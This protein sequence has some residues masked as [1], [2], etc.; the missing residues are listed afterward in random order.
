[1]DKNGK[2]WGYME[3]NEA[4]KDTI[5]P[6]IG[7]GKEIISLI[8]EHNVSESSWL[9]ILSIQHVINNQFVW[10]LLDLFVCSQVST[11]LLGRYSIIRVVSPRCI[12]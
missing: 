8:Y 11:L 5:Q 3:Q 2:Y 10:V 1:M 6:D 9:Y 12:I 4:V 7:V